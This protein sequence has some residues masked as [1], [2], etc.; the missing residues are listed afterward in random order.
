MIKL[1]RSDFYGILKRKRVL[2]SVLAAGL[3]A[4][5]AVSCFNTRMIG[6]RW[7]LQDDGVFDGFVM[8]FAYLFTAIVVSLAIHANYGSGLVARKL[9]AGHSRTQIYFAALCT[10]LMIGLTVWILCYGVLFLTFFTFDTSGMSER[11][12]SEWHTGIRTW[13]GYAAAGLLSVAAFCALI[14]F[15]GLLF[16]ARPAPL[17]ASLSLILAAVF[18][19]YLANY[20]EWEDVYTNLGGALGRI[21]SNDIVKYKINFGS[22]ILIGIL[23]LVPPIMSFA[24]YDP[25]GGLLTNLLTALVL[26]AA[27][28]AAGAAVFRKK[29][30]S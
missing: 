3:L 29:N 5:I 11:A 20:L 16:R 13:C 27:G 26:F 18:C 22:F 19:R 17:I 7:I 30:L 2:F 28:A 21:A 14:T 8:I 6:P 15:F 25:Y 23:K 9:A 12:L 10:A 4:E 1:L 24:P